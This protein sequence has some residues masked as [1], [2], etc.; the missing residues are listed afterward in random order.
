MSAFSTEV[1]WTEWAVRKLQPDSIPMSTHLTTRIGESCCFGMVSFSL[2]RI[3]PGI[4]DGP[5]VPNEVQDYIVDFLHDSKSTLMA[6]ALVC[7][8]WAASS[9]YH[10]FS[11]ISLDPEN[12]DRTL[13]IL[14]EPSCTIRQCVRY[15]EA[16]NAYPDIGKQARTQVTNAIRSL[17]KLLTPSTLR[18]TKWNWTILDDETKASFSQSQHVVRLTLERVHYGNIHDLDDILHNFPGVREL[19]MANCRAYKNDLYTRD[20]L[21]W[22][23]QL[24]SLELLYCDINP[25]LSYFLRGRIVPTNLFRATNLALDE[26]PSVGEYFSICGDVVQEVDVELD[27]GGRNLGTD[28]SIYRTLRYD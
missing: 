10:L 16:N 6:C 23:P 12:A 28:H 5:V 27:S 1:M 24:R 9:R 2:T 11:E 7:K 8:L 13:E 26:I 20:Y 4:K 3:H 21:L 22:S 14:K 19:C 17:W 25:S 18:L 15:L